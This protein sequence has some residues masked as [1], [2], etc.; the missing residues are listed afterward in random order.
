MSGNK[1]LIWMAKVLH[2]QG[3]VGCRNGM[4]GYTPRVKS[5]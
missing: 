2:V 3:R 1:E 5:S 4:K